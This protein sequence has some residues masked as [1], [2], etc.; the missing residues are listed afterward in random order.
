MLAREL[1][2]VRMKDD[3]LQLSA[4]HSTKWDIMIR[5]SIMPDI[6]LADSASAIIALGLGSLIFFSTLLIVFAI[7][8][9]SRWEHLGETEARERKQSSK[10]T[11]HP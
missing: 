6:L 5:E 4:T 8:F 11:D 7:I 3:A 10:S 1:F 9:R 2:R